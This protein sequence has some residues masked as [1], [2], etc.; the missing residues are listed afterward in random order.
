MKKIIKK[1]KRSNPLVRYFYYFL[2]IAYLLCYGFFTYNLLLLTGIETIIRYILIGVF[3]FWFLFYAMYCF[4][5]LLMRKYKKIILMSLLHV[6]FIA[7]F[8]VS[9]YYMGIVNGSLSN[10]QDK[11]KSIYTS[12]LIKLKNAEFNNES[13]IGRISNTNDLEG[14]ELTLKLMKE[15]NLNNEITNYDDYFDMIYSLYEKK[16]NAIFVPSNYITLYESTEGLENIGQETEII[17]QYQEKINEKNNTL[18]SN[19]DFTEP[20]TFLLMGVDSTIDGLNPNAGFNGDTLMLISFNPKTLD[21]LMLSVPRDTYVPIVCNSNKYAKINSSAAYGSDCVIDTVA[22]LL[23]TKIDYYVKINFKGVVALVEAMH[24]IEV[25][26][27]APTYGADKYGG[28][29]CEQ[30]SDRQF[31]DKLICLDPGLQT[32]NGEQALAYSRN[33]HL[34]LGSDLDRIRHQQQVVEAIAKKLLNFSTFT[35][36]KDIF[37]AISNNIATNMSKDKILSSYPV[38]KEMALNALN[39][40]E[41]ININKA[42]LETYS[43]PVYLP[44]SGTYTSAQGYYSDSLRD[45]QDAIKKTLGITPKEEIKTFAFSANEEYK[46]HMAGKGLKKEK[47]LELMPNLIGSNVSVAEEFCAN[48]NITLNK[49]FVDPGEQYY[50]GSVGVGLIGD[51]DVK[52]GTLVNNITELTIYIP[53]SVSKTPT[54]DNETNDK[55]NEDNDEGLG[56]IIDETITDF[57]F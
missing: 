17:Y 22:S 8:I 2:L 48:H 55:T 12:Y 4:L 20:L 14:Y 45:V 16:I 42:T 1:L 15:H 52:I 54:N 11:D 39:G 40:E 43:L 56:D 34:Y 5:N 18:S 10:L 49:K 9:S 44:K 13:T 21:T 47:S 36:F 38:L 50:N 28:K 24:G 30:N 57:I 33:R 26:V 41:F 51:Q 29:M 25:D 23:D 6:V 31:G 19:K 46:V 35:D 37:N 7:V 32:L 53:N 27:E 3:L